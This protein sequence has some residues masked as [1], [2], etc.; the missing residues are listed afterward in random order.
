M[1]IFT[2]IIKS[3][4][5]LDITF[6][7]RSMLF[8]FPVH[9]AAFGAIG[10]SSKEVIV[11]EGF[12]LIGSSLSQLAGGLINDSVSPRLAFGLGKFIT[13]ISCASI[14]LLH[15]TL[16]LKLLFL[17]WGIGVGIYDGSDFLSANRKN[18]NW[19]SVLKHIESLG[20]YGSL[21]SFI[22]GAAI[23][24]WFGFKTLFLANAIAA[25]FIP[26]LLFFNR[27]N[28]I[29]KHD[30]IRNR[31]LERFDLHKWLTSFSSAPFIS[32]IG[33]SAATVS[34][35]VVVIELQ[36]YLLTS[37]VNAFWNGWIFVG[38]TIIVY[39]MLRLN[40]SFVGFFLIP[41]MLF[42]ILCWSLDISGIYIG[43]S[44]VFLAL[45]VRTAHKT[46][47]FATLTENASSITLGR[48]SSLSQVLAGIFLLVG[49]KAIFISSSLIL[50]IS[51]FT[52]TTS[53]IFY[54]IRRVK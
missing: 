34:L 54:Q 7:L 20:I 4:D 28:L 11:L 40:S 16:S 8:S 33:Y 39:F 19:S 35:K 48:D 51:T 36:H 14:A 13:A 27:K 12:F 24:H 41:A 15:S 6:V 29:E 31:E 22:S 2:K 21:I 42:F 9:V 25:L 53:F 44:I 37:G 5:V 45:I 10:V 52:A 49:T 43:F 1:S 38:F 32:I 50:I 47:F 17:I 30:G 23:F 46:L 26:A 18:S 3:F